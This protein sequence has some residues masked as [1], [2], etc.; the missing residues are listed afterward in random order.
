MFEKLKSSILDL[1]YDINFKQLL[2]W[3]TG[4]LRVYLYSQEAE[5]SGQCNTYDSGIYVTL[6]LNN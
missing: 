2:D 4:H 5:L 1:K 3:K 6:R